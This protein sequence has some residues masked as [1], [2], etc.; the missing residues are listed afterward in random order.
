MSSFCFLV[1]CR[2]ILWCFC[3][4]QTK[5]DRLQGADLAGLE[6]KI[7]QHIGGGG[8]DGEAGE[9]FGQ[10]LVSLITYAYL[11]RAFE[12]NFFPPSSDGFECFH[13]EK[14]M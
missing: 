7:Q 1:D 2:L 13:N 3:I 10:G 12:T 9:D 11:N 5:I 14:P 6:A 4:L 8:G